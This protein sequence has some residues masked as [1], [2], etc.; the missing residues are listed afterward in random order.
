MEE[1]YVLNDLFV[2]REQVTIDH[3]LQLNFAASEAKNHLHFETFTPSGEPVNMGKWAVDEDYV[4]WTEIE[5]CNTDFFH[6]IQ[7]IYC[8]DYGWLLENFGNFEVVIENGIHYRTGHEYIGD[9]F[10]NDV[11]DR[12]TFYTYRAGAKGHEF[13]TTAY[14][15]QGASGDVVI[16]NDPTNYT[17]FQEPFIA[18]G[19]QGE[20]NEL[21]VEEVP[22][23]YWPV[24]GWFY[25]GSLAGVTGE[26]L[27][28]WFDLKIRLTDAAGNWQ[29]QVL[30]PAFR[31]DDLAYSSVA[32]VVKDNAHE[33]ARY[34]LAGQRVDATAHKVLVK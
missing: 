33:V 26:A 34:N 11:S 1:M 3:D 24:M 32:T 6:F 12:Y 21:A 29:E 17:L 28:G 18:Q 15:V 2:I 13:F 20:G 31:I 10:V 8:S 22:E 19:Y 16:A 23:N 25:T 27:N 4:N 5:P 14:E 9:F 30:S 7:E